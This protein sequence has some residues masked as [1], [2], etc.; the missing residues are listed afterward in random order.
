MRSCQVRGGCAPEGNGR[1]RGSGSGGD[2]AP[3]EREPDSGT[4]Y[5]SRRSPLRGRA[6]HAVVELLAIHSVTVER[7]I[8]GRRVVRERNDLPRGQASGGCSQTLEWMMRR[9]W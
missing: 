9:R 6:L 1:R 3:R 5:G 4:G 2:V 8:G 7:E